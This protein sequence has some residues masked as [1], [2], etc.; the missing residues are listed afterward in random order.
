MREEGAAHA[1]EP[2]LAGT[3]PW[4]DQASPTLSQLG[5]VYGT[6]GDE[7]ADLYREW[8]A[9]L[10]DKKAAADAAEAPPSTAGYW[11]AEALFA[12]SRR[13]E[14]E[15]N[16]SSANPWR[17]RELLAALDLRDGATTAEIGSAYRRLAKQHHPDRYVEA[18]P[19]TQEFHAGEMRRII[20]AYKALRELELV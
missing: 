17:V 7:R 6:A 12:D 9:R 10:R 2:R 3:N 18:D 15:E 16:R 20:D 8:A 11:S 19:D 14:Q 1:A 4:Q 13:V 5:Q